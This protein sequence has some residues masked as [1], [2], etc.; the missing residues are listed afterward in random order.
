MSTCGLPDGVPGG[1]SM[2]TAIPIVDMATGQNATISILAALY[3]RQATGEGQH[4]DCAMLDAA[5][6]MN[7]HLA[8][9]YFMTGKNPQRVGNTNPIA[10]P[11]EV[12]DCKDGKLIIAVG[13]NL[14]F[15]QFCDAIG[16]SDL[17]QQPEFASNAIRVKHR[18]QLRAVIAPV[19]EKFMRG[20]L[21]EKFA[22][23]GVPSGPLNE[24]SEVF[25]SQ[26]TAHRQLRLEMQHKT[27][28]RISVL[29]SPL[30]IE[31][32][33]YGAIPPPMLG[34]DTAEVLFKELGITESD[35]H[36]LSQL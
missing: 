33:G 8:V 1:G 28:Q 7:G 16:L 27:G 20:E 18:D 21:I 25:D 31:N 30:G 4:I 34:G 36:S 13:N 11:S 2:R 22:E 32:L 23:C 6:A 15:R 9:G 5:V 26:Q 10:S 3:H 24:I 17:P 14:Q 19:I 12:F 35:L 29:K